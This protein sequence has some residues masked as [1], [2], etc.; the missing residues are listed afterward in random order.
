MKK[1]LA[2]LLTV[3]M[4]A[5]FAS[6]GKQT[7]NQEGGYSPDIEGNSSNT[8]ES[9]GQ[10]EEAVTPD[11][12]YAS[13]L[14][15]ATTGAVNTVDTLANTYSKLTNEKKLT[16]AYLGGSV[17]SGTG[18]SDGYCWRSA[19]TQWFK[20]NFAD[21]T[22]TEIDAGWGG[23]G[24]YWG[25][26]R[27]DEAVIAENPDL[28]FVEFSINDAYAG[29]TE[30]QS[31]YYMEGIVKKLRAA[32]PNVD[33]VMI[34]VTDQSRQGTEH[35]NILGHKKV[36]QHYGI[37]TVN[38]GDALVAEIAKTGNSWDYYVTDIVHPNNIGYKVYADC[39]AEYLKER[40]IS[41][42]DKS[43][44]KAHQ[45]P[46]NDLVSN[47]SAVSEIVKAEAITDYTGF[48]IIGSKSNA[49]SHVGKTLYGSEGSAIE[50][51]FEGRALGMLVDG[52]KGPKIKIIVDD[53][54]DVI[55][56]SFVYDSKNE[57]QL[58]ENLNY[59]K[60][61]VKIEVI[62]GSKIVIGGFLVTK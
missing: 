14:T 40:L 41:S 32:N 55:E 8:E 52:E 58:L 11:V 60:H 5:T 37:P 18:G 25:F 44:L 57:C 48:Q 19:T 15:L 26:F 42:P 61:K 34:F 49:V 2:F 35:K 50:F 6:C 17:T 13:E 51:E 30:M 22:I 56:K 23:T 7:E 9:S 43:G 33:I 3:V 29:S 59:G 24:S 47:N 28:V 39:V 12:L 4:L 45:N 62:S 53:G 38:V 16:V 1:I 54:K 31:S 20:D 46:A 36:A 27:I 21:A 10:G